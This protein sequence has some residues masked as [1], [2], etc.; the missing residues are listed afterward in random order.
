MLIH[1]VPTESTTNNFTFA[2]DVD[3]QADLDSYLKL[4]LQYLYQH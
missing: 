4:R 1:T 2:I 3:N